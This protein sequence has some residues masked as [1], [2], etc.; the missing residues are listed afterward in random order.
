M[1]KMSVFSKATIVVILIA[2]VI[3]AL[4]VTGVVAKGNN[5]GLE[6][7]W[8]QLIT[9]FNTQSSNHNGVHKWVDHWL[10]TH[11][12]ASE[13]AEVEKHL[14]ICNS[15]IL[16]AGSIVSKHAGFDAKGNVIERASA[17]KSIDNLS[18][19]L[20][21]HAGSVK[22]LKEHMNVKK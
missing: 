9:N 3:A 1:S 22:N 2:L 21:Q 17:L 15:A 7:K 4:P 11:K 20:R 14:A 18:Y 13:R 5:E 6:K 8:D 16:S 12:K 10:K 19:F